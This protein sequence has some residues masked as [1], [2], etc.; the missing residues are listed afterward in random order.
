MQAAGESLA[1]AQQ[2]SES[3]R[4]ASLDLA[5]ALGRP[6]YLQHKDKVGGPHAAQVAAAGGGRL[7][8]APPRSSHLALHS[9]ACRRCGS[10][11]R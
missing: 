4:L 8:G 6:E 7:A 2:S 10:M 1:E 5:K 9:L 3:A 11:R